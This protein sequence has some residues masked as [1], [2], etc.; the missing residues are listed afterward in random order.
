MLSGINYASLVFKRPT[1]GYSS[2]HRMGLGRRSQAGGKR[3]NQKKK[4][5]GVSI[6]PDLF[7]DLIQFLKLGTKLAK[8]TNKANSFHDDI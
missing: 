2:L 8:Q 4:A 3:R 5:T 1:A 6:L 7:S